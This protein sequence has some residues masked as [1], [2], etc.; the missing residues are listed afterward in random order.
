VYI[1]QGVPEL[2]AA[3]TLGAWALGL[4]WHKPNQPTNSLS[5]RHDAQIHQFVHIYLFYYCYMIL[6]PCLSYFVLLCIFCYTDILLDL[7]IY[8]VYF[9]TI[10]RGLVHIVQNLVFPFG[11]CNTM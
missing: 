10:V 3:V 2:E 9:P 6:D 7:H 11:D 1:P 4:P 8:A 5:N